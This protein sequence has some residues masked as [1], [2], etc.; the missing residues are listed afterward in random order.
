MSRF[1]YMCQSLARIEEPIEDVTSQKDVVQEAWLRILRY[2]RNKG[3]DLPPA[4]TPN[5]LIAA[6]NAYA[7]LIV[8]K[9]GQIEIEN[10]RKRQ[11]QKVSLDMLTEDEEPIDDN[12]E[13]AYRAIE[14]RDELIQ[15]LHASHVDHA[16][17]ERFAEAWI[18][19]EQGLPIPSKL[20]AAISRDRKQTGLALELKKGR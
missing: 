8:H 3:I 10:V 6:Y 14:Q 2:L 13:R 4:T 17:L 18:L 1:D 7:G 5:E 15:R 9:Q 20:S 16:V 12:G 11:A 19:Q